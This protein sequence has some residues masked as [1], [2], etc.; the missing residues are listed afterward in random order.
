MVVYDQWLLRVCSPIN[1]Q[2]WLFTVDIMV[3]NDGNDD[4][5]WLIDGEL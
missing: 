3:D 4:D 1:D 2:L 5:Q